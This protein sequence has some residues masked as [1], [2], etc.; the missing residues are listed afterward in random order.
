LFLVAVLICDDLESKVFHQVPAQATMFNRELIAV[1]L[2]SVDM[3][4]S[5]LAIPTNVFG[6]KADMA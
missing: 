1:I 5:G 2:K 6:G 4:V 3:L